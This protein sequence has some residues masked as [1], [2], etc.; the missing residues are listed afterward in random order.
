MPG[1]SGVD[2]S[3]RREE[4]YMPIGVQDREGKRKRCARHIA[5][6]NV[7]KPGDRIPARS[8]SPHRR[9]RPPGIGRL[10]CAWLPPSCRHSRVGASRRA[11]RAEA[12]GHATIGRWDCPTATSSAPARRQASASRSNASA[13][14]S[15]GS[16]PSRSPS[17]RADRSQPAGGSAMICRISVQPRVDLIA[18]LQ[19]IAAI[20]EQGG[21]IRQ[22]NRHAGGPR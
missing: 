17:V 8:G 12:A 11:P 4:L 20:D 2:L 16:K 1:E 18:C 7:Q 13:V 19:G 9:P 21:P 6:P 22:H 14:C 10:P 15:Q 3:R 5:A